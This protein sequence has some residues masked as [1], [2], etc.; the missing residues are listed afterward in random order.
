LKTN[1]HSEIAKSP[2]EGYDS[3]YYAKEFS[4]LVVEVIEA[5]DPAQ[6]GAWREIVASEACLSIFRQ[7]NC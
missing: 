7:I 4:K 2:E 6:I 5:I 3:D 1:R